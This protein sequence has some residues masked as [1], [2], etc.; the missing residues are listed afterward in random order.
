MYWAENSELL[1]AT[2]MLSWNLEVVGNMKR[3]GPLCGLDVRKGHSI[4]LDGRPVHA[5]LMS[6]DVYPL[7]LCAF[8][9]KY[10]CTTDSNKGEREGREELH[11]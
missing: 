1:N 2:Q 11:G 9:M 3:T 4:S 6:R 7:R 10:H 8:I 5:W